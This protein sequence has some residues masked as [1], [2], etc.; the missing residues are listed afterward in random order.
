MDTGFTIDDVRDTLTKDMTRFLGKIES[1]AREILERR[2]LGLEAVPLMLP[3]F[4]AVG[5]HG[6]AIYGTSRLVSARSL[7]DSAARLESLAHAGRDELSR[8]L[9]HLSRARD[10]AGTLVGGAGDMLAMLSLEL[11]HRADEASAIAESWRLRVDDVMSTFPVARGVAPANGNSSVALATADH[12]AAAHP[13]ALRVVLPA[14]TAAAPRDV[15]D[16][17]SFAEA[18]PS[19]LEPA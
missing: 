13:N 3:I 10:I 1:G 6:H 12:G 11:E 15:D 5:D 2:D 14:A 19:A 8:A 16:E 17:W 18:A 4:Q 7:A 9:Q